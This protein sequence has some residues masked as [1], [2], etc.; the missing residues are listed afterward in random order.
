MVRFVF[1]CRKVTPALN[2]AGGGQGRSG[3]QTEGSFLPLA[4]LPNLHSVLLETVQSESPGEVWQL[5][6]LGPTNRVTE[7]QDGDRGAD[8]P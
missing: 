2:G 1:H 4:H 8:A 5:L 6:P 7:T 3:A